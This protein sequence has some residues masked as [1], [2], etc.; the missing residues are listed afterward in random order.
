MPVYFTEGD[1][2]SK[3]C[4]LVAFEIGI[5]AFF[6]TTRQGQAASGGAAYLRL[7]NL[8][9]CCLRFWVF[10]DCTLLDNFK[11]ETIAESCPQGL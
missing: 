10:F 1:G 2:N 7:E 5:I 8:K 6:T 11:N 3:I 4:C 9:I